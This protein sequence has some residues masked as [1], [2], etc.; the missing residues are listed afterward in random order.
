MLG[1]EEEKLEILLELL[2]TSVKDESS[3]TFPFH[4]IRL[5][6]TPI[7]MAKKSQHVKMCVYQINQAVTDFS[8]ILSFTKWLI[9]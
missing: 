8:K 7:S 1:Q 5:F 2:K 3:L 6:T 9:E 4:Y